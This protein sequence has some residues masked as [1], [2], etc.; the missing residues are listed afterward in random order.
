MIKRIGLLLISVLFSIG[1]SSSTNITVLNN[2]APA[3]L[4]DATLLSHADPE[5]KL[6]ILVWLKG[7]NPAGLQQLLTN[8]YTPGSSQYHQF[9]TPAQFQTSY[10]PDPANITAVVNYLSEQGLNVVKVPSNGAFVQINSTVTQIE[11]AFNLHINQYSLNGK[12]YY[13]NDQAVTLNADVASMITAISGLDNFQQLQSPHVQVKSTNLGSGQMQGSGYTPQQLQGAYGVD[14]LLKNNINGSGQVVA[15]VMSNDDPTVEADLNTY[16]TQFH[17]PSCASANGCLAKFNQYGEISPL[18]ESA[19]GSGSAQEISSDTQMVHSLAPGAKIHVFEMED[20]S[21]A[22]IA[23]TLNTIVSGSLANIISNSYAFANDI[24]DSPVEFIF[25]Q[26]A[27]QGISI[28]FASG[29]WGDNVDIYYSNNNPLPSVVYP[30]SSPWVTA[31]GGT[32]LLLTSYN[33]YKSETGWSNPFHNYPGSTGGLSQYYMAQPWQTGAIGLINAGGYGLV[34]THRAVPDISMV[35]AGETG[36]ITY[37]GGMSVEGTYSG[38][39]VSCPLFSA[40]I[41]LANQ[42]RVTQGLSTIGL[43]TPLLYTMSYN[44]QQKMAP[45]TNIVAPA[46]TNVSV[47]TGGPHWNDITGLGSPYAP[48]FVKYLVDSH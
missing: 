3:K 24:A 25:K 6:N 15:I 11:D 43:V 38:T 48:L 22:N 41:A 20:S 29:D 45:I 21:I 9:I 16:S 10:A 5:Q 44:V 37:G 17:L 7:R 34:G 36:V 33:G 13:S 28:N 14:Q 1:A 23:I 42:Q 39:S 27:A 19:P 47:L 40:I 26:G 46:T 30:A 2:S 8:L 12:Q 4:A 18:P 31:V 32:T 35:A